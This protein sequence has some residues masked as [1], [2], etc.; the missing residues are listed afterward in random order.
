MPCKNV[1]LALG[2]ADDQATVEAWRSDLARIVRT[3]VTQS[4]K[5][6]R[7]IARQLGIESSALTPIINGDLGRISLERLVKLCVRLGTAGEARWSASAETAIVREV[8]SSASARGRR[9]V[10]TESA[11]RLIALGGSEKKLGATRRRR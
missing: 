3:H 8:P 11:R 9:K 2:F 6:R 7:T 5:T 4:G 1:F 10:A